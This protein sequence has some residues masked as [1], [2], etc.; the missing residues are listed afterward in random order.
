MLFPGRV[1][2]ENCDHESKVQNW[3]SNIHLGTSAS[4]FYW[5][6]RCLNWLVLTTQFWLCSQ[7]YHS[8]SEIRGDCIKM[9][10]S[11]RTITCLTTKHLC[12]TGFRSC[13]AFWCCLLWSTQ[14]IQSIYD[15][16]PVDLIANLHV[17]HSFWKLLPM[18]SIIVAS[19]PRFTE[20]HIRSWTEMGN[21]RIGQSLE[22]LRSYVP[23]H[24]LRSKKMAT[25][26]LPKFDLSSMRYVS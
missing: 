5:S 9:I 20:L 4:L 7:W 21:V 15:I 26:F 23:L 10:C 13:L 19:L 12:L 2:N 1:L 25:A 18:Q 3:T 14:K 16:H 17:L 6:A 22:K 24:V 8:G 11:L